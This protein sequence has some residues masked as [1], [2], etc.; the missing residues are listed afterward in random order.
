MI[1]RKSNFSIEKSILQ[2]EKME[3][4]G[5]GLREISIQDLPWNEIFLGAWK[6]SFVNDPVI[7]IFQ[8]ENS[9]KL[10]FWRQH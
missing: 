10:L 5:A 1:I 8:L 7:V 6:H 4:S 2:L 3:R 9:G